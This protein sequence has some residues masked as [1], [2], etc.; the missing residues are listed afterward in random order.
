VHWTLVALLA[1]TSLA[2]GQSFET[3]VAP[4]ANETFAGPCHYDLSLPAGQHTVR[5]VWVTF[6]RG[7]DVMK[8]IPI[9]MSLPLPGDMTSHL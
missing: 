1:L 4:R 6:D 3:T 2:Q 7:R 5:A 9:L 8:F